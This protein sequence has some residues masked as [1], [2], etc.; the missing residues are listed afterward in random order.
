M[1]SETKQ[2]ALIKEEIVAVDYLYKR[3]LIELPR[4][5][6]LKRKAAELIGNRGQY[7]GMISKAQQ[8][9]GETKQRIITIQDNYLKEVLDQ[10]KEVE[11][12]L[13]EVL[14]KLDATLD[15]VKRTKIKAPTDGIVIG[16]NKFTEGGV[17]SPSEIVMHL[18]PIKD[19]LIAEARVNPNDIELIQVGQKARVYLSA[20]EQ[21]NAPVLI[22]SVTFVSADIVIDDKTNVSYYKVK[23]AIPEHELTKLDEVSL[24]P[25]MQLRVMIIT[26]KRTP[27]DY[28]ITPIR[29][30]FRY[31][32]REN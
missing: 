3:K 21:R 10:L 8:K 2:L 20:L 13:A 17:I 11:D 25:G 27:F 26:K 29:D 22:G 15:T 14:P 5:L 7:L 30:S 23:V 1:E 18:L 12:K 9:I 32:F 24:Y 28:F 6:E 31:A 4:I 19:K 16:L